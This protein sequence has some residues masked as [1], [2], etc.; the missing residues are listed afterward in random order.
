MCKKLLVLSIFLVLAF[1][2][3]NLCAQKL[4]T[5]GAEGK[6]SPIVP[7]G[8]TLSFYLTKGGRL[9]ETGD[10]INAISY[11]DAA[12]KASRKG[13]K[14]AIVKLAD[15]LYKT[16]LIY[17][18]AKELKDLD[19]SEEAV[20]KYI[21]I[22]KINP[23]DPKPLEFI[24]EIYDLLSEAAEKKGNYEE[25][26]R[27]YEEWMKFAPQNN[28]PRESRL[29]NL[30][31]AAETAKNK[32]DIGKTLEL[33]RR[34]TLLEPN[35]KD[36]SL[37]IESI[38]KEDFILSALALLKEPDINKAIAKLNGALSLYPNETRL[39]EALRQAQGQKELNQ[40]ENLMKAFKYNEAL[41]VYKNVL[42]F[43]PEKK[44]YVDEKSS[45]IFL[46]TGADYQ[47][48]GT[49]RLKGTINAIAR[50]Q[51]TGNQINYIEGREKLSVS[52]MGKFPQRPFNGK[53]ERLEGDVIARIIESPN[54]NNKYSLTLELIPKKEQFF[55]LN[56]N[57]D[58][59]FSGAVIWQGRVSK[60]TK[61]RLQT[62][63]VDQ[64]D[65]AKLVRTLYDPLPHEPYTLV[66][67]KTQG[68][69]KVLVEVIEKP[70]AANNYAATVEVVTGSLQ[71]ED[72]TLKMEWNLVRLSKK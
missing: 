31:L 39:Q 45:E 37:I 44:S 36:Y 5:K 28:F 41:R 21:E 4:G 57:W 68:S 52:L 27:L 58:L 12:T 46:R 54:I 53:I 14:P 61:I 59:A 35:N 71:A 42:K 48:D 17:K 69:E 32:G 2:P 19:K 25:A 60:S 49:L 55:T 64:D 51:I 22:I 13:V 23:I 29:K 3:A 56:L 20:A 67:A 26:T 65:N 24:V 72:I 18:D 34:L 16:A 50:I 15:T 62:F 63:F 47:S 30:K 8:K 70:T 66:V 43:F 10:Y 33:Y 38:E 1:F 40:A 7:K 11:L 9:L 6:I